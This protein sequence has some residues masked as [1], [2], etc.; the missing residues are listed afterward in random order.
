M[1]RTEVSPLIF[2][3]MIHVMFGSTH[4]REIQAAS[5]SGLMRS[6][7]IL[8]CVVDVKSIAQWLIYNVIKVHRDLCVCV[9]SILSTE[10][11]VCRC[12]GSRD[13]ELHKIRISAFYYYCSQRIIVAN[14]MRSLR[15]LV[16]TAI[17]VRLEET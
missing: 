4:G 14:I 8:H 12:Y 13:L 3:C 5:G 10:E 11:S 2:V 16:Y 6:E 1:Q 15:N 7:Q 9:S 17:R